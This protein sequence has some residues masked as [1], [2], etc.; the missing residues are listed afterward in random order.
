MKKFVFG[1]SVMFAFGFCLNVSAQPVVAKP[2]QDLETTYTDLKTGKDAVDLAHKQVVDCR[3]A[4]KSVVSTLSDD[5]DFSKI[6]TAQA[7]KLQAADVNLLQNFDAYKAI[8][9][10]HYDN[11]K[12]YLSDVFGITK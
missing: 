5:D 9:L 7:S 3:V 2:I 12:Q 8:C 10:R 4:L 6:V 11:V 1:L